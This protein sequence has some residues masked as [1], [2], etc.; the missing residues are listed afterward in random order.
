[1]ESAIVVPVLSRR[2]NRPEIRGY[3]LSRSRHSKLTMILRAVPQALSA[4]ATKCC[5]HSYAFV[6]NAPRRIDSMDLDPARR[7]LRRGN[8][9]RNSDPLGYIIKKMPKSLLRV[10]SL[11]FV[12][13]LIVL[14]ALEVPSATGRILERF[15]ADIVAGWLGQLVFLSLFI[16][17]LK[18]TLPRAVM[19]IPVIFYSSYYFA[20]WTQGVHVKLMSD[21]LRRTNPKTILEFNSKLHS[22]VI[23]QADV[24]AATHSIPVVYARYPSYIQDGYLSYRLIARDKIKEY[25]TRNADD[26]QILSVDW[27]DSIQSNVRELRIPERPPHKVITV[28]VHDANGEGWKDW[29]IGFHTTSLSVEGQIVGI[30]KSGYVR[31]LP[32][33][34]FFTIGCKFSSV[35]PRRSCQAEFA[36]ERLPIE[37]RPNSVDRTLYPDPVS[38]MLGIKALSDNQIAHFRNSDVGDD[39]PTRGAPGEDAAF[40]ALRDIVGERSPA[41]SWATGFLIASNPSRLAPFA[42]AMTK[43][44][45]DLSQIG[46]SD[47]PGRLDQT[48]LLAAGIVAL[49]PTEFATVQDLLSDLARRDDSIR[50]SYPLLYLRLADAGPKMYSIYR[51]QFLAQNATQRDK[52]LAVI[53]ICRIGQADNELISAINSEWAKFDSGELK[54]NNYQTALFIALLKLGQE[55]TTKNSG[56]PN[57]RILQ[58]WYEAVLAGRGKTDIGP[59]NCMPM[60]WPEN[61]YVPAFLAPSLKWVNERWVLAD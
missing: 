32:I 52:L 61:T 17:A 37:S 11:W 9:A 13:T 20:F 30:F 55:S 38:I 60:E 16:D 49:G 26:V 41:L 7:F 19:I 57:S 51:D 56:R 29:N 47:V 23:D 33:I 48:R 6:A 35:P 53:A 39:P 2:Q 22:L 3:D 28:I 45:L 40:G 8:F 59:N 1:M 50:D 15:G 5:A 4:S 27:D 46:A 36:T 12:I 25:L 31:R 54:G 21:D 58:G 34:P 18:G 44:F 10:S 43:R 24:F 42:A 14:M